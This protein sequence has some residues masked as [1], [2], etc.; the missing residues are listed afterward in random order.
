MSDK[1]DISELSEIRFEITKR[2]DNAINSLK[3]A[4][5]PEDKLN[6]TI[7]IINI[8]AYCIKEIA[9]KIDSNFDSLCILNNKVYSI[10]K[11]LDKL[12]EIK[13]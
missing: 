10:L 7:A 4:K 9:I 6:T 12:E 3:I 11:R 2:I 13:N 1:K 8:M 5:T